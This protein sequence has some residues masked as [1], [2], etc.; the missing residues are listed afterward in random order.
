MFQI[1]LFSARKH[2]LFLRQIWSNALDEP[3]KRER[4]I[5]MIE[6]RNEKKSLSI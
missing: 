1:L 6:N 2:C 5:A 4:R 3:G